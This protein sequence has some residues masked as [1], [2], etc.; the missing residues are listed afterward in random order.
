MK[1]TVKLKRTIAPIALVA[2]MLWG[3]Y[4]PGA[5]GVEPADLVRGIVSRYDAV[6]SGR[7]IYRFKSESFTGERAS[8]PLTL[9]EVTTSFSKSS[10]ADRTKGS[11]VV[12]INHDGYFLEFVQT[13]QRDGSVRPGAT[14]SPQRLL[15]SRKEF[16]APPLFA[17]SF[18]HRAQL[19]FVERHVANSRVVGTSVVNSIFTTVMEFDVTA[20]N[21]RAAFHVLLPALGSGGIVRLY[22]APQLGFVLPRI[23]FVTP[24]K[25]VAQ[26]YDAADFTEVATG[27]YLP[28]R[29]W[30]ETHA[31]GG[32]SRYRG[33]FSVQYELVNQTIPQEDFVVELPVGTRVQDAREPGS[34]VH[35]DLTESTSSAKLTA[36]NPVAEPSRGG[37]FLGRWQNVVILGFVIGTVISISLLLSTRDQRHRA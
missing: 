16:N 19:Q 20:A 14:L 9:P 34:V 5:L 26:S 17:G 23:E 27:I 2:M 30:T 29:L 6:G 36:I 1:E 25:Q 3:A 8:P 18:W 4:L 15:E 22:V 11:H 37:G 13:P 12:R 31:A 10:W 24:S 32:A 28:A 7:L 21:H 33:E 35:F